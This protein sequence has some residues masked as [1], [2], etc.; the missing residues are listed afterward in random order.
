MKPQ[1]KVRAEA[2]EERDSV[3]SESD[4]YVHM[5]DSRQAQKLQTDQERRRRPSFLLDAFM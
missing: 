1:K 4:L 3:L 2:E 5:C